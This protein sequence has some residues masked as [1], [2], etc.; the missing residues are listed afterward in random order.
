MHSSL[1]MA[2]QMARAGG[3]GGAASGA[4]EGI[5]NLVVNVPEADWA[6]IDCISSHTEAAERA[7]MWRRHSVTAAASSSYGD[8]WSVY[9]PEG[10]AFFA[11]MACGIVLGCLGVFSDAC[12]HWVSAFRSGICANFFWLGRNMC[13]VD[14]RE[15]GEYYSWGEFFLGRD[16]HVVAFVDFVMYVSFSTMAAVTA[17]YLC[18]TYAPYASG[19]GIA[20]VKTIVSGHHVKRY[21][22]GWTLITKV[23]GMCF[24]TGSG[25]TVGKEGPFVHIGACVGGIISGALPS[26]QQEAKERE[27]ITAGAGGGMAVA[28]GAPV[29]GVIFALEDVSTSYNFKALMA[30]L[31]C[32]VT[33]VLL[34]SRV[35]LWHTGRIVQFSVNYQHN[36][37][38]FELPMFA[39]IG[40]FGGFIGSTFS[41]VNLHVGRWRKRHL[42]QWRIVEVA[43]VAAVTAVVNFLTP[44]GSGSMLELLG[45]CF[46]D[47]TPN[48][49]IE[50]CEDSDMRAF[51]SLLVT[52]TA[53]FAMFSYTVG[54]FLPAGILVPS[55]TIGALYGRAFGMMF[56]ALQETYASSYIFTECYD[57][58]LC[59]IPG[60]YAIVGAAAMLTGVTHMTICLAIIMFEL[61]G[62]LE[63]MVPVIVGILCAKAAGEAVGVKGTYEIGIEENKLPYLDPKKEFYLDFVAQNVYGNKQFTVLTAY[64]LQVRDINELVTKMNVTGFPVV[65]SPSDMT[66]L[67]Y[68]PAKKIVRALQVAAARN[69]DVNLNTYIRFKTTPSHSREAT[70]LEVDLTNILESC[71]LQVEPECSVKKLLYLF[72]SLGTHHILVCRYSKFEGFIS[73]KDFINFMRVKE[74]EENMEDDEL[75]RER[76]ERVRQERHHEAATAAVDVAPVAARYN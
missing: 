27:L 17:A 20:E 54:T 22:G 5:T 34:Q 25:L 75:E 44:Y 24:S 72:K 10:E 65:E 67:G 16:N 43:V 31:I 18:K 47:C 3:G 33:A 7:A 59:V 19:G 42:R 21:L 66:L 74:R 38:F 56:R 35:D 6:T 46:Q 60:V 71:L 39:A 1:P 12:A 32:G 4:D 73:K 50:M 76:C 8:T 29:G 45:D 68:A 9:S 57:Q 55:L 53:K 13:C 40:C 69:S 61:T 28:F 63:Y 64:G 48:G 11:A 49:T 36:W 14:S 37:H 58:D 41:V 15:C 62:S 51:F 52:A 26:Y 70:F 30:A 2:E 23:V